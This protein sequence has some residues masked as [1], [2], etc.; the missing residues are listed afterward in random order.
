[1]LYLGGGVLGE[2]FY[3]LKDGDLRRRD[4]NILI[5][6]LEGDEKNLKVEVTDE[7]Y[8]F[9]EHNLNTKLLNFI[10]QKGIII[11]VFNYYGFYSGS[12]YP[13]SKY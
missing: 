5:T 4:N 6:G 12:Y 9:G 10:S 3:I 11:H 13:R 8:L 1:M 7:I 2:T